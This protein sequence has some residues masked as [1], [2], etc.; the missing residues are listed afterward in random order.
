MRS[1]EFLR[2]SGF[3]L[4]F[5]AGFTFAP[6]SEAADV[7]GDVAI[8]A[9]SDKA[10]PLAADT[11]SS[12]A[13][14][15]AFIAPAGWSLRTKPG[16]TI[17]EAPEGGSWIALMDVEA[18]DAQTA[19]AAAWE[20]YGPSAE[21]PIQTDVPLPNKDGWH[22][23]RAYTFQTSPNERRSVTAQAMQNG[24]RWTVWIADLAASVSGKREAEIALVLNQFLPKGYVRESFAGRKA[25]Q[26]DA[27]RIAELKS[28]IERSRRELGVPGISVGVIQG[29]KVAFA[30]GF[31]VR[32][33][34]KPS[35]VDAG[36]LYLIASNTKQLTTLMLG[37]LV[38]QHRL[39]W[40]T[41]VTDLLPQFKL[42]DATTTNKV[43]VK[44]LL[45]ACTGLPRLDLEWLYAPRGATPQLA[46]DILSRMQPTS[47]FGR[48]YQ[49][50]NPI[51]AAAGLVG[52]HVAYPDLELG[53]AYD[54]IM[55]EQ[56][57]EPL[58]MTRTT[59]DFEQAESGNYA[60]PYAYDLDGDVTLVAIARDY[61]IRAIRPAGGAWSN[62]ED[63][64]KYV[65]M[66]LAG[67]VLPGG[68]RY[69]SEATLKARETQQVKTGKD[70]WYGMGLETDM[71]SGTPMVFH[72][73]RMR[74]YRSNVVWWPEHGVGAV[75][76]TNSDSGNVLMDAFPRKLLEVLF[77]GNAE[78]DSAVDA[79]AKT[80]QA[81]L[82]ALRQTM[83]VPA[84]QKEVARLASHYRNERLGDIRRIR[85]GHQ[86]V[87]DFGTWQAPIAS[88]RNS[89]G[90][91]TFV[92]LTPSSPPQ[93][94]AGTHASR[95]TLTISDAQH[96]YVFH[97]VTDG[98]GDGP[99]PGAQASSS[100]HLMR[101]R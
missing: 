98:T 18:K 70:S 17:L 83:T 61:P 67:G 54:R 76:L 49:Y 2:K 78:A 63:L 5:I 72:G 7:A 33:V 88:H 59:F 29:G 66:E 86:A 42:G 64:L 94:V 85:V 10:R 62:V 12:T 99:E 20:A 32:E 60:R 36:T 50:S 8:G 3:L 44:H 15:N 47:E 24:G 96:E 46:L 74:G 65:Q 22:D 11:P 84:E 77:D 55:A 101:S 34:G 39:G 87:F 13:K 25:H 93:L 27:T 1:V 71:S 16:A 73:G 21:R 90:T 37:K 100:D 89:D 53:A 26:L 75:I 69:I 41:R 81:Q 56:V 9:G 35:K 51:A 19:L 40:D 23:Q 6:T 48:M 4:I 57:F 30:E 68:Q 79:A 28:F 14:G 38:D 97:E 82:V 43:L 95:R 58:G 31:G 92:P 52:G 45:C 91:I 80:E